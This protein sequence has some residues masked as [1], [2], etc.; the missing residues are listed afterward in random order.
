MRPAPSSS[1]SG[2]SLV[3][4]EGLGGIRHAERVPS[5]EI[6]RGPLKGLPREVGVMAA[7]AYFVAAGFGIVA[8]AIPVFARSFGVSRAAAA[9][10]ISA[11]A[12]MRFVS[13]LGC[14]RLVNRLGERIVL[15]S[16]I[17]LVAGSSFLAGLA[18]SYGQLLFLRGAGGLGSAMFTVSASSLLLR[19]ASSEHRGRTM[20][21]FSGGFLLG[22][23]SGP[24]LG[25]IVTGI[26]LRA[27]FF[28]YSVTLAAAGYVG[29]MMLP[30]RRR[31]Q[32]EEGESDGSSD[33]TR[34][35]GLRAAL[36]MPAFRAAAF[37]QFADAWAALGVRSAMVPL[38]VTEALHRSPVWTGVGFTVFTG[39]NAL[40]LW[41]GGRISDA[42]GRRPVL[43]LGCFGSALGLALFVLPSS[44]ITFLLAMVLFGLGSGFLD[45]APGA[46][47]GDVVGGRGGT[48]IAGFQMAGDAGSFSG[49]LVAGALADHVGF[50]AAFGVTALVL[51]AAGASALAAPETLVHT[52]PPSSTDENIGPQVSGESLDH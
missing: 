19:V 22:G 15:G 26:S 28:I 2:P 37:T 49:P 39:A 8:P 35:L 47:L 30:R 27:P 48:V 43:L 4:S 40:T 50:H 33:T 51:G 12:F 34:P 3:P 13:A 46:M 41:I 38:Y 10:V 32:A 24:A 11:F 25:G 7:V 31:T 20:G 52:P 9:A 42:R 17:A 23:I 36:H 6:S 45:V 5:V 18:Q 1:G 29:L 21:A 16:G 44:L 14:G